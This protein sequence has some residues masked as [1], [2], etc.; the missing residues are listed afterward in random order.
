MSWPSAGQGLAA[1]QQP[2]TAVMDD[3]DGRTPDALQLDAG[4]ELAQR[5]RTPQG[6]RRTERFGVF[7]YDD[8][9]AG[10]GR[11]AQDTHSRGT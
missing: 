6:S 2:V 5:A 10:A 11:C 3:H 8:I 1:Y 7:S 9:G 4:H